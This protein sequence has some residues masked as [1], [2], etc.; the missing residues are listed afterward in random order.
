MN[1]KKFLEIW[2]LAKAFPGPQGNVPVVEGFNLTVGEG[3]IISLIGHSGC[4][5][6][7]V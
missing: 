2:N 3:E 7:T 1:P 5:K 6:S 4:G